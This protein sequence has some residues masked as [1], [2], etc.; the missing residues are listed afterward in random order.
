MKSGRKWRSVLF[1]SVLLIFF[2]STV[3]SNYFL[4]DSTATGLF[5][6]DQIL[7]ISLIGN[8]VDL[9]SD[10]SGKVQEFPFTLVEE[11]SKETR[12]EHFLNIRTRGHYRRM[13][14]NCK[15]PPLLL[16]FPRSEVPV[17]S[18]FH[19]Q[20]K[21][22]LVMP[23]QGDRYVFREYL[24]YKLNNLLTP[25]SYRVRLVEVRFQDINN[26]KKNETVMG[27]LLEDSD[28]LA[29][30][31]GMTVVDQDLV[32]PDQIE[33]DNFL[34]VAVFQY[35]IGNT[36]WS[37]QYR[38]NIRI[39][40][41]NQKRLK[42]SPYDFDHAGMVRAPYAKPAPELK[43]AS[44]MQRRYRGYCMHETQSFE[45]ALDEFK[46]RK[47]DFYQVL[48]QA[49]YLDRGS[50]KYCKKYLDG[51]Y[52]IVNKRSKWTNAFNYPCREGGT[53]NVVIKGLKE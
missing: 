6:S 41:D 32:R 26:Q 39:F 11:E 23:C 46:T 15:Y 25:L 44:V 5:E 12:L 37:V 10:R 30:R 7:Q 38:Q 35:L 3:K 17:I 50:S 22:K 45:D 52:K 8:V 20:N 1:I 48:E 31:N 36:D 51:F 21:L 40:S 16:D 47:Q 24:L 4:R 49:R 19:G 13:E 43:M 27:F 42:I 33:I 29:G 34:R 18:V 53:G 28:Q 9:F 2:N 14:G